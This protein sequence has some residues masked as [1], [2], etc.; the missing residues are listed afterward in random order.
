MNTHYFIGTLG[1]IYIC[2]S[3]NYSNSNVHAAIVQAL[4]D[5]WTITQTTQLPD[6]ENT[7]NGF[8][9]QHKENSA[10]LIAALY[11]EDFH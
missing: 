7:V 6:R 4:K 5:P 3:I 10:A 9:K 2:R 1:T 11:L 8:T